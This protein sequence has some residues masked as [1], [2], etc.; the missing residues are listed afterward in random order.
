[1]KL[2][3]HETGHAL[4]YAYRLNRRKKWQSTFGSSSQDYP[5]TYRFRPYSKNFV[6]HLEDYYAQYHP[7]EDFVETFAVWLTPGLD[8]PNKYQGWRALKKLQYV[9]EL[10]K[11]IQGL[12]PPV[13]HAEKHWRLAT[14]K[15]TLK[16]F[17]KKK[18]LVLEEE[19]PDFHDIALKKIL[20]VRDQDND[21]LPLAAAVIK[22]YEKEIIK[23]VHSFTR[24]KKYIIFGEL[25]KMIQRCQS[26]KLVAAEPYDL[27]VLK[28]STYL[29]TLIM[30]YMYTGKF[31]GEIKRRRK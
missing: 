29:T 9:D 26:L 7:D 11:S 16:N 2:L 10:M 18:R 20:L 22:K 23:A 19:F 12:Q 14:L 3:R 15:I 5:D 13:K 4:T 31:K 1:M 30:N 6:R 21:R 28:M 24:E 25:K 17:Y 27:V 8:W